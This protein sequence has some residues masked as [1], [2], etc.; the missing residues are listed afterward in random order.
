MHLDLNI[1]AEC[2]RISITASGLN[3]PTS[4]PIQ[5]F[6]H[7]RENGDSTTRFVRF[8]CAPMSPSNFRQVSQLA[9]DAKILVKAVRKPSWECD[10]KW[11]VK[12]VSLPQHKMFAKSEVANNNSISDSFSLLP[13]SVLKD[14]SEALEFFRPNVQCKG[15]SPQI[16]ATDHCFS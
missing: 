7:K 12:L 1:V 9:L 11:K 4:D 2:P 3:S 14:L 13:F 5:V 8:F 15:H 10:E 16:E 6:E